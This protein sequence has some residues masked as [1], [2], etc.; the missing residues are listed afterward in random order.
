[1]DEVNA[2][3]SIDERLRASFYAAERWNDVRW[4]ER[5]GSLH[6]HDRWMELLVA[7]S[8]ADTSCPNYIT[9]RQK[10]RNASPSGFVEG[11]CSLHDLPDPLGRWRR[12]IVK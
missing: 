2:W 1:M 10:K 5:N 11:L 12:N 3:L 6:G 7:S 8:S 9:W 4:F